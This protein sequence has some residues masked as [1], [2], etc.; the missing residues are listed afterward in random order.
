MKKIIKWFFN[1]TG[2]GKK[3]Y[4]LRDEI[5]NRFEEVF[6]SKNLLGKKRVVKGRTFSRQE[7]YQKFEKVVEEG[8]FQ[9]TPLKKLFWENADKELRLATFFS[10]FYRHE[11][12]RSRIINVE[13][14]NWLDNSFFKEQYQQ[15]IKGIKLKRAIFIKRILNSLVRTKG[16]HDLNFRFDNIHLVK[17]FFEGKTVY[18]VHWDSFPPNSFP[19]SWLKHRFKDRK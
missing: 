17:D 2:G 13:I 7:I 1:K 6:Y 19:L 11:I 10:Y 9:N 5:N 12:N 18:G 4:L 15:L 16:H 14:S 8:I 3:I